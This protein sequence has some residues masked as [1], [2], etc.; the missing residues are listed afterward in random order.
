MEND[1]RVQSGANMLNQ[2][3]YII[4]FLYTTTIHGENVIELP[5][6]K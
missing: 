4:G 1:K 2:I 5:Q 3:I 6:A